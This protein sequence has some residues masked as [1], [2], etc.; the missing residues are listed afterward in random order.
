MWRRLTLIALD[1]IDVDRSAFSRLGVDTNFE[2]DG[3]VP[4]DLIAFTACRHMKENSTPPSSGFIK[5][6]PFSSFHI[7][8][9]PVAIQCPQFSS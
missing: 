5:P 1:Q 7:L 6:K 8:I 4:G 3:L 2:A 9:L